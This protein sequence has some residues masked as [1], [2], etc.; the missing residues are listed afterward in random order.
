M[1]EATLFIIGGLFA[2]FGLTALFVS[3]HAGHGPVY[4]AGLAFFVFCIVMIFAL[5][6]ESGQDRN[7]HQKE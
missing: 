2:I 5:I 7:H 1:K 4:W 6:S 3:A